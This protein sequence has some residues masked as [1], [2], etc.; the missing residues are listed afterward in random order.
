MLALAGVVRSCGSVDSGNT[1]TDYL[2]AE[3]ERGITIQSAAI[4]F[5]WGWH[6]NNKNKKGKGKGN[7]LQQNDNVNVQ[8]RLLVDDD[9]LID[10]P[11]HIDFSVEVNRSVAVLDGA[12]L[13]L[14]AVAGVQ[15]QTETVWRAITRPSW[16]N[17]VTVGDDLEN[18][19]E[20]TSTTAS[21]VVPPNQDHAH[22]PLPCLAL[23]NKMDKDGCNFGRAVQSIREKL[24]GAN[25]IPIQ[26]PLFATAARQQSGGSSSR[27]DKD[28]AIIAGGGSSSNNPLS[29]LEA[30]SPEEL[31]SSTGEFVGVIDLIHM[32]AIVWPSTTTGGSI[33]NVENC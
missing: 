24:P 23:V 6:N 26:I 9:I 1:V 22:E 10:T 18:N 4:S 3:Q 29:N 30:V 33:D 15:A 27:K 21:P 7:D 8:V 31:A 5:E 2:P 17:H 19:L 12:V 20:A 16:N 28:D 32:R 25:P 14:D 13:V 11:G